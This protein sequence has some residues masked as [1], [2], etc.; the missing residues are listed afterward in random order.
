[1]SQKV[2][3]D[4]DYGRCYQFWQ[5]LVDCFAEHGR[6]G[7]QKK[8]I[9]QKEDYDECLHHRKLVCIAVILVICLMGI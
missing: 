4:G 5:D 6:Y 9:Q 2:S 8:C 1:M 7:Q 3:N